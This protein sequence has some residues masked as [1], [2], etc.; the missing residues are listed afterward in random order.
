[1]VSIV[2]TVLYMFF[3]GRQRVACVAVDVVAPTLHCVHPAVINAL[4]TPAG[5]NLITDVLKIMEP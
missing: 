5:D 2:T 1:M 3:S 4:G